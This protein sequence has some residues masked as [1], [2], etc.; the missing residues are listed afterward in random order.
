MI[1]TVKTADLLNTG[2]TFHPVGAH[3]EIDNSV[4]VFAMTSTC[5]EEPSLKYTGHLCK[6]L[7]QQFEESRTPY[8]IS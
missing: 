3:F 6:Q 1:V 5:D 8:V 2:W 7:I 4:W